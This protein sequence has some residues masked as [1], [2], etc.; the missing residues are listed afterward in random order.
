MFVFG[1]TP[2]AARACWSEAGQRYGISP[3]LLHSIARVE[4]SLNA[5]AV[6]MSHKTRTGTY[7]I[8]LMQINSSHL[9]ELARHG[10]KEADLFDACTNIHVGAWI[11]A[12]KFARHGVTW[13][14]VGA[15]NA[16]C[17]QLKGDACKKART[18]YAW[19]VYR[20]M[21]AGSSTERAPTPPESQSGKV[22]VPASTHPTITAV[23]VTR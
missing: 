5:R 22:T 2:V 21:A 10:I 3:H 19:R 12:Q 23:R 7:D 9:A 14:G 13:E 8:G 6:N 18:E 11:L 4:S 16:G 17:S 1:L 20:A 15:Y